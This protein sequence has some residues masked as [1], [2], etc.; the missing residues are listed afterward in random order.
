[1]SSLEHDEGRAVFEDAVLELA[2][3]HESDVLNVL[4]RQTTSQL[5]FT[6]DDG[7]HVVDLV[8]DPREATPL[9]PSSVDV[10]VLEALRRAIRGSTIGQ[11]AM[12]LEELDEE[13]LDGLRALGYVQ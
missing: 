6:H 4:F 3:P 9:D 11:T 12:P 5:V 2:Y 8:E 1:M 7:T 13:V 10:D